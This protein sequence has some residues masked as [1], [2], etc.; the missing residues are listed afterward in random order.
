MSYIIYILKIHDDLYFSFLK[1]KKDLV[2]LQMEIFGS[3]VDLSERYDKDPKLRTLLENLLDE[4]LNLYELAR[5]RITF[6]ETAREKVANYMRKYFTATFSRDNRIIF[7]P[8]VT[9]FATLW[10]HVDFKID[11]SDTSDPKYLKINKNQYVEFRTR[12]DFITIMLDTVKLYD[13]HDN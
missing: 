6:S 4:K 8:T 7:E 2:E 11:F 10:P 9:S 13:R 3:S 12:L 5:N 1:S